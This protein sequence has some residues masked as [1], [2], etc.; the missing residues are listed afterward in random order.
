MGV[1]ILLSTHSFFFLRAI[2][3]YVNKMEVGEATKY[4]MTKSAVEG[5]CTT[6]DVTND[7]HAVYNTM[8]M[9]LEALEG[10]IE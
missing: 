1:R 8:Y 4:Y 7:T 3:V 5:L 6:A 10:E 9:P 2:E